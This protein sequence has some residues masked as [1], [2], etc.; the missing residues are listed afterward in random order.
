MTSSQAFIIHVLSLLGLQVSGDIDGLTIYTNRRGR[1]VWYPFAPPEKPPSEAQLRQRARF[2]VA[3]ENWKLES[4]T[5]RK[6]WEILVH[7]NSLPLTGQNLYISAS[8]LPEPD[9]LA[10]LA[11]HAHLAISQPPTV[12]W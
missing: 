5:T 10:R 12:S 2:R 7:R 11:S 9:K 8:L 1:I 4:A 6:N 3:Q